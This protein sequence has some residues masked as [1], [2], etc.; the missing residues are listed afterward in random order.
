MHMPSRIK[1]KEH[2]VSRLLLC[3]GICSLRAPASLVLA[4]T[5]AE[6]NVAPVATTE[7]DDIRVSYNHMSLPCILNMVVNCHQRHRISFKHLQSFNHLPKPL[8]INGT[9]NSSGF[10]PWNE[11]TTLPWEGSALTHGCAENFGLRSWWFR[12]SKPWSCY[13]NHV[14]YET[15][16]WESITI[17]IDSGYEYLHII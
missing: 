5:C 7:R 8:H 13:T 16:K 2:G 17:G 6:T 15:Y 9:S 14:K 12:P 3:T 11:W 10:R 4:Q 1:D